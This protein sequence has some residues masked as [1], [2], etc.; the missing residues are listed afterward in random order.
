[1]PALKFCVHISKYFFY[2]RS[3][4]L[5]SFT[6]LWLDM[7]SYGER[8]RSWGK[9]IFT[10]YIII[11][12]TSRDTESWYRGPIVAHVLQAVLKWIIL[13][14]S[15]TSH[16]RSPY[17]QT[18]AWSYSWTLSRRMHFHWGFHYSGLSKSTIYLLSAFQKLISISGLPMVLHPWSQLLGIYF[19]FVLLYSHFIRFE[20]EVLM[21]CFNWMMTKS[22]HNTPDNI[23]YF[24]K[25]W[26]HKCRTL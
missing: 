5:A 14:I 6:L 1:M 3:V 25:E 19:L 21:S 13:I 11:L 22:E 20:Q 24:L 16:S 17:L 7:V 15:P 26:S 10:L 4:L 2:R 12:W 8:D 18:V 9:Q 23:L